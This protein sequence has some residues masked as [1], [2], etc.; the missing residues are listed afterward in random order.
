MQHGNRYMK[1]C[2]S[3][4]VGQIDVYKRQGF[5]SLLHRNGTLFCQLISAGSAADSE[6][7]VNA[8]ALGWATYNGDHMSMYGVNADVPKTLLRHICLLYT[9]ALRIS[10]V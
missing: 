8:L 9:S 5:L 3:V 1:L 4:K 7:T 2:Q 10:S 6:D